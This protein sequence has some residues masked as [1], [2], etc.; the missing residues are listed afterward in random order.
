M[1]LYRQLSEAI[2]STL[3]TLYGLNTTADE[4]TLTATRPEF[5]GHVTLVVFPFSKLR[6]SLRKRLPRRS[7]PS[8]KSRQTS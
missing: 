5:E 1:S 6:T 3:H 2:A 4:I 8:S 7:E